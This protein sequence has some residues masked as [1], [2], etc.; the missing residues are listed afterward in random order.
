V[1]PAATCYGSSTPCRNTPN[2]L[3]T[4]DPSVFGI[5]TFGTATKIG[6]VDPLVTVKHLRTIFTEHHPNNTK[7][8]IRM[9]SKCGRVFV[10]SIGRDGQ[11]QSRTCLGATKRS[12]QLQF[13]SGIRLPKKRLPDFKFVFE[14][15]DRRVDCSRTCP[16]EQN[17]RV[18][19]VTFKMR[20]A[21]GFVRFFSQVK[22]FTVNSNK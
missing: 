8:R 9:H 15:G 18:D 1:S 13:C 5:R 20:L 21:D 2:S 22:I 14:V 17:T 6:G 3:V 10:A 19:R 16:M 12:L 7:V 11:L 4:A